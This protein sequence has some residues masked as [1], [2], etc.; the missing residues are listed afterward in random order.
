LVLK[1]SLTA[2]VL[3]FSLMLIPAASHAQGPPPP[4]GPG[5]H[6]GGGPGMRMGGPGMHRGGGMERMTNELDLTPAQA[7]KIKPIM[8]SMRPKMMAI[9]Q[10]PKLTPPQKF[11]KFQIIREK[12]MARISHFLSPAQVVKLKAMEARRPRMGGPG[13]H[14]GGPGMRMGGPPHQ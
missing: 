3:C 10:D 11:A 8:D 4:G 2:A 14:M 13:M 6:M 1:L 5:M 12:Q 9:M 7:A